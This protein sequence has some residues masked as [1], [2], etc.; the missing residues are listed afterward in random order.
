MSIDYTSK[1][2][3]DFLDDF[4]KNYN[5]AKGNV[6]VQNTLAFARAVALIDKPATIA[7]LASKVVGVSSI[8]SNMSIP[9]LVNSIS[10]WFSSLPE[11][12]YYDLG[13]ETTSKKGTPESR[14]GFN[15]VQFANLLGKCVNGDALATTECQSALKLFSPSA[16]MAVPVRVAVH[17]LKQLGFKA[18]YG[19]NWMNSKQQNMF[20][21]VQDWAE[22][23]S[24]DKLNLLDSSYDNLRKV[25]NV[26]VR[27]ANNHPDKW[28]SDFAAS[29]NSSQVDPN[30]PAPVKTINNVI[31]LE[32]L[33]STVD[34]HTEMLAYMLP[35]I[36]SNVDLLSGMT[37]GGMVDKDSYISE[38]DARSSVYR[39]GEV[40]KQ[41]LNH[42][43]SM[44]EAKGGKIDA[45]EKT[46]L[47]QLADDLIKREQSLIQVV[48]L[49][50]KA[51]ALYTYYGKN[52]VKSQTSIADLQNVVASSNKI[53]EKVSR[54]RKTLVG[55]LRLLVKYLP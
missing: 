23:N 11:E 44:I 9:N 26:Y 50:E 21:N 2:V 16:N 38:V 52:D 15:S 22:R 37:G 46:G 27:V 43:L 53:F 7:D 36:Y 20:E 48:S 6:N 47:I 35:I 55:A 32:R 41:H 17:L 29:V 34:T 18:G 40:L 13:N 10:G 28:E 24:N 1:T 54:G 3:Q 19:K 25:L 45:G 4:D 12:T 8:T 49:L 31:V 33:A 30:Y 51:V 14:T 42:Y 39:T 5:D